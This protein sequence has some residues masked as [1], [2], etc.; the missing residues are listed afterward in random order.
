MPLLK[1]AGKYADITS[2]FSEEL[3]PLID[4][5]EKEMA[6]VARGMNKLSRNM[7]KAY[8][9]NDFYIQDMGQSATEAYMNTQ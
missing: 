2:A 4:E 6:F 5:L 7:R 8:Q 1:L 3:R 9:N